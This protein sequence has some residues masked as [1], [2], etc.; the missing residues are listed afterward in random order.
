[1]HRRLHCWT[2]A[3]SKSVIYTV[4]LNSREDSELKFAANIVD[5]CASLV[6]GTPEL[7][8]RNTRLSW[9]EIM[10]QIEIYDLA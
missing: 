3:S 8:N 4:I 7:F 2:V 6:Q 9:N 10:Q 1:M 5:T